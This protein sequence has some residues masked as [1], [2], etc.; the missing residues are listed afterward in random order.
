M[1]DLII[2]SILNFQFICFVENFHFEKNK[3]IV[4]Q[5]IEIQVCESLHNIL[6]VFYWKIDVQQLSLQ[7]V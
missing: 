1:F 6:F 2:T 7:I 4:F 3:K 5:N